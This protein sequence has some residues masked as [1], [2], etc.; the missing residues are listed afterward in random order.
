M[1][2]VAETRLTRVHTTGWL[3]DGRGFH[4]TLR[5]FRRSNVSANGQDE[6]EALFQQTM[7]QLQKPPFRRLCTPAVGQ[8]GRTPCLSPE[9]EAEQCIE[10]PR[11]GN[12]YSSMLNTI[13]MITSIGGRAKA[14]TAAVTHEPNLNK[15]DNADADMRDGSNDG[16]G[17]GEGITERP[18]KRK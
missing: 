4:L 10:T 12:S 15:R 14:V 2:A 17:I 3:Y 9:M 6:N 16:G 11:S 8:S 18:L 7:I 13:N 5:R 1:S